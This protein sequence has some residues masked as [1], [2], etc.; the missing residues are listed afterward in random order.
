MQLTIS[1]NEVD[2]G[3][4]TFSEINFGRQLDGREEEFTLT[5]SGHDFTNWFG[6][7]Y[8]ECVTELIRDDDITG[9][10]HPPYTGATRYP[11]FDEFLSMAEPQR[12]EMIDTYF[13]FDIL[14][15]Y[16]REDASDVSVQWNIG[17]LDSLQLKDG[18][19]TVGGRLKKKS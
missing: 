13:V 8:A 16:I 1:G 6:P 9:E 4:V 17:S 14:R 5:V 10:F 18:I 11:S 3:V 7:I 12:M 2:I 19:L 15:H